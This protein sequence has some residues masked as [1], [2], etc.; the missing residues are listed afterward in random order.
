MGKQSPRDRVDVRNLDSIRA[1]LDADD[2]DLDESKP[3]ALA[4]ARAAAAVPSKVAKPSKDRK[5]PSRNSE[6]SARPPGGKKDGK[7]GKDRK[8]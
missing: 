1:A 6:H 5:P 2:I 7:D 8:G 4:L 3:R